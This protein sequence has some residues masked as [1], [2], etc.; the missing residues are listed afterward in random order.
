MK[1]KVP[2]QI[3]LLTHTYDVKFDSKFVEAAG[4][5]GLTRHWYQE[6]LLDNNQPKS[7]I[8]QIFFHEVFHIIER[9]FCIKIDDADIERFT[10]GL[11][12]I[13]VNNL[14]IELDWSE[15]A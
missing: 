13:L 15:I 10:E 12:E 7:E 3:K 2:K 11:M 6:I 1:V 4:T 9:R 5:C 8:D 14:G